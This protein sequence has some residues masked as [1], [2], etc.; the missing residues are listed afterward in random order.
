MR[1]YDI[2]ALVTPDLSDEDAQKVAARPGGGAASLSRSFASGR[3][4]TST[5]RSRP[6]PRWSW[7]PNGG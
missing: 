1:L 7:R 2:V 6:S 4:T 3:R 5:S